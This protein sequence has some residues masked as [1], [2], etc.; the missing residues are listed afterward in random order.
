MVTHS[1][2][3]AWR[4]PRT[5]AWQAT[6]HSVEKSQTRL[7]QLSTTAALSPRFVTKLLLVQ[8]SQ[9]LSVHESIFAASVTS[10]TAA[11]FVGLFHHFCASLRSQ[12]HSVSF[13]EWYVHGFP[14]IHLPRQ[15]MLGTTL[16]SSWGRSH[17]TLLYWSSAEHNSG[18]Y[19]TTHH[20]HFR[21]LV[22]E[23][24]FGSFL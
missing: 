20:F 3:L 23:F 18:F 12:S 16:S 1:S 15:T 6:V 21:Y 9:I 7:K 19:Y 24:S 17:E 10:L 13:T 2:I 4:T 22:L 8:V 14:Q 11:I 5:G